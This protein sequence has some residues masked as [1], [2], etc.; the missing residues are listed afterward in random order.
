[1]EGRGMENRNKREQINVQT[2]KNK[3]DLAQT[4]HD[5]PQTEEQY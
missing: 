3:N 5:M 4:N 1:M 2:N